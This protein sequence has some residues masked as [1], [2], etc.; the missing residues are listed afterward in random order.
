M[1]PK[2][3]GTHL[4]PLHGCPAVEKKSMNEAN[5]TT[6][7]LGAPPSFNALAKSTEAICN[8]D[9]KYCFFLSKE[10]LFLN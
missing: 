3:C 7:V 4:P 8:L 1:R 2:Q 6:I 5:T 10:V 9:C